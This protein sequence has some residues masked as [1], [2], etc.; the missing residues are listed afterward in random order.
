M[1]LAKT[2]NGGALPDGFLVVQEVRHDFSE[3][4]TADCLTLFDDLL[5]RKGQQEKGLI[6]TAPQPALTVCLST[7]WRL[8][9]QPVSQGV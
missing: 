3:A 8:A 9:T 5:F 7:Y 1:T 2:L 6:M 4:K